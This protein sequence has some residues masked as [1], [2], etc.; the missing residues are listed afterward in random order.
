[1]QSYMSFIKHILVAAFCLFYNFS[2]AQLNVKKL[3]RS[4][5]PRSISFT[6]TLK[7]AVSWTDKAGTHYV[8][9][10]ETGN[11]DS[12]TDPGSDSRSAELFAGHYLAQK[13]SLR[14]TWKVYDFIKDCPVDLMASFVKNS[15]AVTDLDKNG[16]AEVWLM[17]KTVCHGDVSP[18]EMK[19]IM[20]ENGKKYAVRGTTKVKV[21]EKDYEGGNYNFDPAFKAAPAVFKNYAKAL[22][23]KNVI[24]TWE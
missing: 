22:W 4:S 2:Q 13:D 16:Q 1:M 12:R 8:V 24:E 6:G 7:N 17:Y 19:I 9:T 14:L 5:L 15:F 23:Q 10:S 11:V 18:S 21:S 3:D 20:Y